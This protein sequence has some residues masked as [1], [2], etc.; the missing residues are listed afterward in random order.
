MIEL[1]GVSV[2]GEDF[3]VDRFYVSVSNSSAEDTIWTNYTQKDK[4]VEVQRNLCACLLHLSY[5]RDIFW[6]VL[7]HLLALRF[8]TYYKTRITNI[9]QTIHTMAAEA[10]GRARNYGCLLDKVESNLKCWLH[11]Y[12]YNI[13]YTLLL[14]FET[15]RNRSGRNFTIHS[16]WSHFIRIH[17]IPSGNSR[18]CMR[19]GLYGCDTGNYSDYLHVTSRSS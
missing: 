10:L 2:N 14:Q 5:T 3:W 15:W 18:T 11:Q 4:T 13:V 6:K 1:E 16:T 7:F 9:T 17:P 19:I 12:Q 8:V